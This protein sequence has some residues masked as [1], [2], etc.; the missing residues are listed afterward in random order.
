MSVSAY[1]QNIRESETPR[2][3]ER[4]VIAT[5]TADL[6]SF[7][8]QFDS[9]T[10]LERQALLA[11]GLRRLLTENQSIWHRLRTD[12]ATEGNQL[13]SSL[14]AQLI[15]IS[16]WVD[17]RTSAILGGDAGIDGLCAINRHIVAGLRGETPQPQ[18]L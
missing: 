17:K 7:S 13:P 15:S 2:N 14:R 10:G 16:L 3:I 6:E 1:K 4:R 9:A 5:V 12:L 18:E 11:G 8:A